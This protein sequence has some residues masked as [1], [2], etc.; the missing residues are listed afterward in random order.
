M[1]LD[2]WPFR[3]L[4]RLDL[5]IWIQFQTHKV[6]GTWNLKSM[7]WVKVRSICAMTVQSPSMEGLLTVN[8]TEEMKKWVLEKKIYFVKSAASGWLDVKHADIMEINIL[9]GSV[10]SAAKWQLSNAMELLFCARNIMMSGVLWET[11]MG[12]TVH[13][14]CLIHHLATTLLKACFLWGAV[15]V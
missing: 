14:A 3:F 4:S 1:R 13:L 8:K 5:L 12:L 11:V 6:S 10:I 9:Y 2:L 7:C 15:Y